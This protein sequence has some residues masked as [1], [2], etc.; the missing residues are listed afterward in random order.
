MINT[1][2]ISKT[3]ISYISYE[4]R[5]QRIKMMSVLSGQSKIQALLTHTQRVHDANRIAQGTH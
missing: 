2:S 3:T 1:T 4:N 5:K